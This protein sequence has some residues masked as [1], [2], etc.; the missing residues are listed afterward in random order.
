MDT[1]VYEGVYPHTSDKLP[2][3]AEVNLS[4]T[5]QVSR[6]LYVTHFPSLKFLLV[7]SLS[8]QI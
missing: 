6:T 8:L 1:Q 3:V 2:R 4:A 7:F 5:K